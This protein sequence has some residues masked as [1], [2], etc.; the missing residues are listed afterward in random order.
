[1]SPADASGRHGSDAR[2][3][4]PHRASEPA[5]EWNDE[6][7][8]PPAR[9]TSSLGLKPK[10]PTRDRASLTMISG[11][12][13]GKVFSLLASTTLGRSIECAIRI[14]DGNVSRVHARIT[15]EP[16]CYVVEDLGSRNGTFVDGERVTRREL[17]DGDRVQLGA[18]IQLR[19]ALTADDEEYLQR[20]LYESSVRDP[21]TGVFNRKHLNERLAAEV[22]YSVRHKTDLALLMFDL[23][24]FKSINDEFGHLAG[25]RVLVGVAGLVLRTIRIEDVFCRYGG[26][27]FVVLARGIDARGAWALAERIRAIVETAR[28]VH[29]DRPIPVRVSIGVAT[30][31]C[32]EGEPTPEKFIGVAD[33]RLYAAKQQ[34][35]NRVVGP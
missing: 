16:G 18:S 15:R 33:Q 1:M 27:E 7:S 3:R 32:C 5:P 21:L 22:A 12:E 30:L 9:N 31:A 23:D 11:P 17:R 24:H 25:D 29:E 26:E 10:A 34:G 13:T 35:R 14:D 2:E 6:D 28:I 8:T 4:P 20:K 19:F